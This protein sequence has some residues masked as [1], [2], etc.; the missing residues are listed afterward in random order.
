MQPIPFALFFAKRHEERFRERGGIEPGALRGYLTHHGVKRK[1]ERYGFPKNENFH[2][3]AK[4][5]S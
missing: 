2:S 3:G 1:G 4:K 5:E